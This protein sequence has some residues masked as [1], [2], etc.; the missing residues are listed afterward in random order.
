M[1][2]KR[3]CDPT[4]SSPKLAASLNGNE[5]QAETADN[6]FRLL[7]LVLNVDDERNREHLSPMLELPP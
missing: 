7:P 4:A 1:I 5:Q 6:G 3:A 2:L